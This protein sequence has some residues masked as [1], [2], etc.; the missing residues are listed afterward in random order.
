MSEQTY[1]FTIKW[2]GS[3]VDRDVGF[4]ST[5]G[6]FASDVLGSWGLS[7]HG[8]YQDADEQWTLREDTE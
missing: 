8:D 4:A 2:R 3:E 6:D 5:I 7:M 1:I